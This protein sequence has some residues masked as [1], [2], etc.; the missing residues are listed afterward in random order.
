LNAVQALP[1]DRR[2]QNRIHLVVRALSR[3]RVAVE[4]RDNGVGIPSQVRGRIFEPFFT[5][6]PVGIGTGL[7][8]TI[9]HGIVASLGGTLSFESEV[10]TGTV[11]R[12]E[13]PAVG[14][15]ATADDARPTDAKPKRSDPPPR[16]RILVVDDEPIE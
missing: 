14:Q 13:L 10:G 11:F 16:G 6:K 8:L 15:A 3:D 7:G 5:T 4:V 2:D 12:V 9:C 1:E